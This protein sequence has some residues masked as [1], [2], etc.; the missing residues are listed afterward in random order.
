MSGIQAHL[1]LT[2]HSGG[3]LHFAVSLRPLTAESP[4]PA[5]GG[6]AAS[7]QPPLGT[8]DH[9]TCVALPLSN[10]AGRSHVNNFYEWSCSLVREL[11]N[12]S[13]DQKEGT[14]LYGQELHSIPWEHPSRV[15]LVLHEHIVPSI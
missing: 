1:P 2:P 4:Q 13:K 12:S 15:H 9:S 14:S 6:R 7:G 10:S 8:G 3:M 5:P 11:F